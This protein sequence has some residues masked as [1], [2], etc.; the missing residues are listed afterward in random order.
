MRPEV[1]TL[2]YAYSSACSDSECMRPEVTSLC[3]L[4]LL[5]HVDTLDGARCRDNADDYWGEHVANTADAST[6]SERH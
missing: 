4:E 2:T 6:I 5:V 3:G 1:T